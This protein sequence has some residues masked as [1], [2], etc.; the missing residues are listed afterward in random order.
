MVPA[1]DFVMAV[2]LANRDGVI[3]LEPAGALDGFGGF[4]DRPFLFL[5]DLGVA[6]STLERRGVWMPFFMAAKNPPFRAPRR[7]RIAS[8]AL[9]YGLKKLTPIL[10]DLH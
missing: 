2:D 10:P 3:R 8:D 1:D 7:F 5:S 6:R 4:S 9:F